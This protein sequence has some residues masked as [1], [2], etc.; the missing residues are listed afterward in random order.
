LPYP[1]PS[2]FMIS[3]QLG[4]MLTVE[5]T[6]TRRKPEIQQARCVKTPWHVKPSLVL[7]QTAGRD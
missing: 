5:H 3:T 1:D 7:L 6:L 4:L 2:I